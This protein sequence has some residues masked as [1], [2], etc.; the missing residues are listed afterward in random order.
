M[1]LLPDTIGELKNLQILG[2]YRNQLTSLPSAN[3]IFESG[4]GTILGKTE[5]EAIFGNRVILGND[6]IE[7]EDCYQDVPS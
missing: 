5:L 3:D 1:T 4:E 7:V 2:L 6:A